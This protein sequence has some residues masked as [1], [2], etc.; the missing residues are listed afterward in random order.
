MIMAGHEFQKFVYPP[1][2][3]QVALQGRALVDW[4]A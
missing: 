1:I 4:I 2:S 3:A